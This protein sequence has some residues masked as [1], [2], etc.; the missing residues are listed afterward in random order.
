VRILHAGGGATPPEDPDKQMWKTKKNRNLRKKKATDDWTPDD[1]PVPRSSFSGRCEDLKGS[2]YNICPNQADRYIKITREI[3]E[4][5]GRKFTP[6]ATKSIKDLMLVTFT[7]PTKPTHAT[8]M[9]IAD[10]ALTYVQKTILS[11]RIK[12]YL[13]ETKKF[14]QNMVKIYSTIHG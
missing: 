5:L 9:A 4:Y 14:E 6:E 11:G 10:D 1:T 2:I 8:G 12:E 3:E 7:E 13:Y